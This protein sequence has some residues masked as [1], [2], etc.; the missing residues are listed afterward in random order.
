[1]I[2]LGIET[3]CD[4]TCSAVLEYDK[5]YLA[6]S[7]IGNPDSFIKT[8]KKSKF[9]IVKTLDFPDHYNYSDQDIIKIKKTAKDLG[10]KIITTEKDYNRLN[11]LNSDGIEYL[12]IELKISNEEELTNFLKDKI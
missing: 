7:G 2:V 11:K 9:K 1:M 4:E 8:L 5:N 6:F 12:K 10:V 3:S